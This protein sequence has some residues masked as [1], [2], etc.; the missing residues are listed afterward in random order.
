MGGEDAGTSHRISEVRKGARC[1]PMLHMFLRL[2]VLM[3]FAASGHVAYYD[4]WCVYLLFTY[5]NR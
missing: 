3:A 1:P 2:F 5:T 4:L